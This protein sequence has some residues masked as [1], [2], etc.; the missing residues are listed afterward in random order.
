MT[1]LVAMLMAMFVANTVT[2]PVTKAMVAM[3]SSSPGIATPAVAVEVDLFVLGAGAG[4]RTGTGTGR[5]GTGGAGGGVR[6]ILPCPLLLPLLLPLL[7]LLLGQ[8]LCLLL[9][10][11]GLLLVLFLSLLGA[12]LLAPGLLL[13][14]QDHGLLQHA[15]HLDHLLEGL[16][17]PLVRGPD[18]HSLLPVPGRLLPGHLL[19]VNV[20]VDQLLGSLLPILLLLLGQL[21]HLVCSRGFT[22]MV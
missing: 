10:L 3:W 19:E 20:A 17:V 8:L 15:L 21:A 5:A 14:Q 16:G 9:V 7:G 18:R 4:A 11:L 22:S 1:M 2:N 13:S 12:L 6:R